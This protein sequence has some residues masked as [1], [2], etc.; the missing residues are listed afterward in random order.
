[1][2]KYAVLCCVLDWPLTDITTYLVLQ[3]SLCWSGL[4]IILLTNRAT[5]SLLRLNTF[6]LGYRLKLWTKNTNNSCCN[7]FKETNWYRWGYYKTC[8]SDSYVGNDQNIIAQRTGDPG[9]GNKPTTAV[10]RSACWKWRY[11]R[12]HRKDSQPTDL[13][14][15]E[16][17]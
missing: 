16:L 15:G 6:I 8:S 5:S 12:C 13:L 7:W 11:W 2:S 9:W 1:M 3:L 4:M 10:A 17:K 14:T